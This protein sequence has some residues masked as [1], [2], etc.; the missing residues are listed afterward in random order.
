LW[1][2]TTAIASR[3]R[4]ILAGADNW[5]AIQTWGEEKLDWLRRHISLPQGIPSHDTF[6]RV[7]AALNAKQF[8]ACFIRW[9]NGL[10]PALEGQVIAIDGKTLRGSNRRGERAIHLVSAYGSGLG[11][12]LGQVRTADKSNEITAIP[13]LLDALLLKGAIV[14]ID[15]MGC[16]QAI[17]R[18]IVHAGADYVLAVKHN[19]PTLHLRVR[20]VLE[21]AFDDSA[22]LN[23]R[24][25]HSEYID[26]DKGHGR[27]ETR[28]CIAVDA[29][30]THGKP[31]P[32]VWPGAYTV[33][34][35][36]ATRE[37]GDTVS[38]ERRYFVS[39]LPADAR[40]I[41]QAVR[42]HWAIENSHH[43]VLDVAFG[44]DQCRVRV[45]NVAQNFAILRRI[46]MNL[47]RQD[48]STKAGLKI[49]RLKAAT[50]DVYR[51]KLL[52]WPECQ[53]T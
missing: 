38:V 12:V 16:Q 53:F 19:Q 3:L 13:E 42:S 43:W 5:V 21:T 11:M 29:M 8:E 48:R 17:A 23:E 49:R 14:T 33:A 45:N 1:P 40:R 52:G 41:A 51:A 15:A 22:A 30:A 34:M 28:R 36:E 47:L 31:I 32:A 44:E 9:M 46:V 24:S 20:Q 26:I 50:S 25:R 2:S 27:I 7:F 4:A 10:C 6:G 18:Q 39:S 35:V 37:I